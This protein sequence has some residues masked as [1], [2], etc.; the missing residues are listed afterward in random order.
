MISSY[1]TFLIFSIIFL[2]WLWICFRFFIFIDRFSLGFRLNNWLSFSIINGL[3]LNH[4]AY[5]DCATFF[6]E[7]KISE[8]RDNIVLFQSDGYSSLDNTYNFSEATNKFWFMLFLLVPCLW[9]FL[10][11]YKNILYCTL[12]C[13]SMDMNNALVTFWKNRLVRK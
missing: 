3:V 7:S 11:R 12:I 5:T 9:I 10:I 13:N 2:S 1:Q 4:L 6:P 8:F